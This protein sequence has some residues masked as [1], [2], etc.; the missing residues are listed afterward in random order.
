[1]AGGGEVS[2][3]N[4]NASTN[5]FRSFCKGDGGTSSEPFAR[6]GSSGSGSCHSRDETFSRVYKCSSLVPARSSKV[7]SG[8]G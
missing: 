8:V 6:L 3:G 4:R 5:V 1:M 2:V 7:F